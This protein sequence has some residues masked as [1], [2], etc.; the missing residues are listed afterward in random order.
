[1]TDRVGISWSFAPV[2]ST[3]IAIF[4]LGIRIALVYPN[5]VRI[6]WINSRSAGLTRS[7][8]N[9]TAARAITISVAYDRASINRVIII[10]ISYATINARTRT[11]DAILSIDSTFILWTRRPG[12]IR[13]A[14]KGVTATLRRGTGFCLPGITLRN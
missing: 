11:E 14:S 9:I 8:A 10:I 3:G 5:T 13:L 6:I 2:M 7:S 12:T 1:M 4:A